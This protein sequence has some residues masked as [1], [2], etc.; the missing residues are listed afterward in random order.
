MEIINTAS[1]IKPNNYSI[2]EDLVPH[3]VENNLTLEDSDSMYETWVNPSN[4]KTFAPLTKKELISETT[5]ANDIQLNLKKGRNQKFSNNLVKQHSIQI[6]LFE[7]IILFEALKKDHTLHYKS[8]FQ[9]HEK[10]MST[11][12][13]SMKKTNYKIDH[14]KKLN[15]ITVSKNKKIIANLKIEKE[16]QV[17]EK[18]SGS[19]LNQPFSIDPIWIQQKTTINAVKLILGEFSTEI[20]HHPKHKQT[21]WR[22]K[23]SALIMAITTNKTYQINQNLFVNIKTYEW[24]KMKLKTIQWIC[25][26]QYLPI[27]G[28]YI[29]KKK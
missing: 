26:W 5:H 14:E 23:K 10:T 22:S 27:Q 3:L 19:F 24:P 29:V 13:L 16:Q 6:S 7:A 21:L 15:Q 25:P 28:D 1:L 20:V 17:I 18:M 12:K 8:S 4:L 2:T 11:F 9:T